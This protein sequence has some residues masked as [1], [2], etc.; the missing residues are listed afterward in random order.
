M[1]CEAKITVSYDRQNKRLAVTEC[2]LVHN[3]YLGE[4]IFQHY[5]A[6]RRLSKEEEKDVKEI[7]QL[8][9]NSKL[10]HNLI[11]KSIVKVSFSST[12]TP[13]EALVSAFND[14]ASFSNTICASF[15]FPRASSLTFVV[16]L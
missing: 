13:P 4:A 10:V 2:N 14:S 7:V 16:I 12:T 6:A 3:H 15:W 11:K 8:R 1:G 5:P 9:L